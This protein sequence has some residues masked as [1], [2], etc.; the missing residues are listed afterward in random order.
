MVRVEITFFIFIIINSSQ[1][2]LCFKLLYCNYVLVIVIICQS[3]VVKKVIA[4]LHTHFKAHIVAYSSDVIRLLI[5]IFLD[6]HLT[7]IS[8]VQSIRLV[9]KP[10]AMSLLFF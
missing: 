1:A 4:Q 7:I 8:N 10:F 9:M 5:S 3:C 6:L 2:I